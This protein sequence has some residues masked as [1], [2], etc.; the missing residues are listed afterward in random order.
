MEDVFVVVVEKALKFDGAEGEWSSHDEGI[1][2]V[3]MEWNEM[4]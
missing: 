1:Y 2:V 3:K 4:R